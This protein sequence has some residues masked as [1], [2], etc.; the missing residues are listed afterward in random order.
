MG[1]REEYTMPGPIMTLGRR[2]ERFVLRDRSGAVLP[3]FREFRIRCAFVAD[4]SNG[5]P[6]IRVHVTEVGTPSLDEVRV[7]VVPPDGTT[8]TL[9]RISFTATA[10]DLSEPSSSLVTAQPTLGARVGDAPAGG[11]ATARVG[12]VGPQG[13]IPGGIL[14]DDPIDDPIDPDRPPFDPGGGGGSIGEI[15]ER[16]LVP[17]TDRSGDWTVRVHN[18]ASRD[19]ELNVDIQH[20]ETVKTLVTTRVP[21]QLLNRTFAEALLLLG[22]R[23]TVNGGKARL[24]FNTE[25]KRLTGIED[26]ESNVD[27]SLSDINLES[28]SVRMGRPEQTT[29]PA[30]LIGLDLEELGSEID[31]FGPNGNIENMSLQVA[32]W[33]LLSPPPQTDFFHTALVRHNGEIR[34]R[35]INALPFV[36]ANP[37]LEGLWVRFFSWLGD[38]FGGESF[39]E[40]I[41]DMCEKLRRSLHDAMSAGGSAYIH[42]TIVHLVERDHALHSVAIEGSDLVVEHHTL[43]SALDL[44]L[45]AVDVGGLS[46]EVAPMSG[47]L[48]G[49]PPIATSRLAAGAVR[50][51][52]SE[53][54][55]RAGSAERSFGPVLADIGT[56]AEPSGGAVLV[57]VRSTTSSC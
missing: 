20:P 47:G 48:A 29:S 43:P 23:V 37:E 18:L 10:I 46:T 15:F 28:F 40:A 4:A 19:R 6:K 2:T 7:E 22:L 33:L 24:K 25:F 57:K 26:L 41:A 54:P 34:P 1:G 38:V 55:N 39:D 42:D 11:T 14:I 9:D 12:S 53:R 13:G 35:L 51:M 50:R 27:G 49:T 44:L 31:V 16:D 52:T 30:I 21:L 5:T 17:G 56:L 45:D 36:A 3:D 32:I 8:E